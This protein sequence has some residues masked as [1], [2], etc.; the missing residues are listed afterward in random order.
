VKLRIGLQPTNTRKVF[1]WALLIGGGAAASLLVAASVS[2]APANAQRQANA[3]VNRCTLPF[4]QAAAPADSYVVS[5][6]VRQQPV[7]H[8]KVLGYSITTNPGPNGVAFGLQLPMQANWNGRFYFIGV[9]GSG[10]GMVPNDDSFAPRVAAGFATAGSDKGHP[11]ISDWS[12]NS[13]PA[14]ALDNAHRG[15][16]VSTVAAQALTKAY[17]GVDKMYRYHTGCSGGGD[18]GFKPMQYYPEDYDGVLLGW[19]GGPHPDPKKDGTVRS[20][21]VMTREISREPG[22]WLSPA[23]REFLDAKVLQECDAAD[24]A[25]DELIQDS[26]QCKVDFAK[27]QCKPG[28]AQSQCLTTPEITTV[29]NILRDSA[30]PIS[31]ISSWMYLGNTPP[32]WQPPQAGGRDQTSG[33]PMAYTMLNGWARTFLKQPDRADLSN[34]WDLDGFEKAGGKAIFYVGIGDPAFPHVGMENWF[35]IWMDRIGAERRDKIAKLYQVPGWGHCGGGSGPTDGTDVMLHALINWVEKGATP[36]ALTMH[37][38]ADRVKLLFPN[39]QSA[40]GRAEAGAVVPVLTER[41]RD[42][43]VCPYPQIAVFDKRKASIAGA[44]YDAVNWTC[45]KSPYVK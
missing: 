30:S 27:F 11:G 31:N 32:P 40:A 18:M 14:K 36:G 8:C 6:E 2:F 12:F 17:Y 25:K 16:H 4:M 23:M 35:N 29:T 41:S 15:A 43:L 33:A 24:G 1:Q 39:I 28:Q 13:N 26:R 10:G 5:A 3:Q 34:R 7:P 44:V 9:G 38:G 45:R 21:A 19:I 37:R 22:A 20:F 42:F